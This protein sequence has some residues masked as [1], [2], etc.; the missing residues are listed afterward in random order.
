MASVLTTERVMRVMGLSRYQSFR[1]GFALCRFKCGKQVF[2]RV[3]ALQISHGGGERNR[4][5]EVRLTS[6]EQ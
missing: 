1:Y 3:I 2:V 5:P 6:L 4:L